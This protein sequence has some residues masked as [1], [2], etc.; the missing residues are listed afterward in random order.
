M[1]EKVRC[2]IFALGGRIWM[3]LDLVDLC[4]VPLLFE[5]KQ[6]HRIIRMEM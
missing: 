3:G 6:P 5:A 1:N 2:S 4:L